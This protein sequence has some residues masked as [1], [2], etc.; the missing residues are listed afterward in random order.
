MSIA[1]VRGKALG[2]CFAV[3]QAIARIEAVRGTAM[4]RWRRFAEEDMASAMAYMPVRAEVGRDRV[5][6]TG[7]SGSEADNRRFR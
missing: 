5:M 7:G 3:A 2:G 1:A 6:G 4:R